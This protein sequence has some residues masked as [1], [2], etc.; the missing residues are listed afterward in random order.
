MDTAGRSQRLT[1]ISEFVFNDLALR[2][3]HKSCIHSSALLLRVL[4]E[5]GFPEAYPLTVDVAVFNDAAQKHLNTHGMPKGDEGYKLFNEAGC[6]LLMIGMGSTTTLDGKEGWDGHLVVVVPKL[7]G[8]RHAV[9]DLTI[10]QLDMPHWNVSM[11][12]M[13]S[14]VGDAFVSG[15]S[16]SIFKR[17]GLTFQYQARPDD[18]SYAEDRELFEIEGLER[19]ALNIIKNLKASGLA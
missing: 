19:A 13:G 15:A 3:M 17:D 14:G 16:P 18:H 10:V 8:D 12:P 4:H 5:T 6:M 7:N 1:A 9:I 11:Q 2:D